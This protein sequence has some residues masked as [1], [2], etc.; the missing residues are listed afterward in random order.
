MTVSS[1]ISRIPGRWVAARIEAEVK[2]LVAQVSAQRN[3]RMMLGKD[4]VFGG[5]VNTSLDITPDVVRLLDAKI[6]EVPIDPRVLRDLDLSVTN[7]IELRDLGAAE[8]R[9]ADAAGR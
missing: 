9:D 5:I 1:T 8:L 2:P 6:T 4:A 7:P 3:C